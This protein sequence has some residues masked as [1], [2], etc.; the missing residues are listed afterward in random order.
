MANSDILTLTTMGTAQ[1]SASSA[2]A[3]DQNEK[4]GEATAAN[5]PTADR[6]EEVAGVAAAGSQVLGE[7]SREPMNPETQPDVFLRHGVGGAPC[8]E[9]DDRKIRV[10]RRRCSS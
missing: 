1:G 7:A 9:V 4:V 8:D 5:T 3:A 2:D 6:S 10:R